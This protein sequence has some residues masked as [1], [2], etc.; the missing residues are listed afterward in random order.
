MKVTF[1]S[2]GEQLASS[3][4]R[5]TIPQQELL[6][7]G[8]EKGKDVLIYGKHFL[9]VEEVSVCNRLIFDVCDDHFN[10]PELGKYYRDHIAIADAVT[11]NSEVMQQRIKEVSGRN[12]IIVKEPYEHEEMCPNIGPSLFWYGHKSNLHTLAGLISELEYPV[13]VMSNHDDCIQWTPQAFEEEIK[14]PCIVIIPTGEKKAKSENRMVEAIRCGR[15]VC[16]EHLPSYKPFGEFFPLGDIP[17]HIERA[18]ANPQESIERIKEAQ[19]YIRERYSPRTIAGQ[20]MEVIN[21]TY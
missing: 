13:V 15:Y 16:A 10:H 18:L 7:M 9:S 6:K 3:R 4:L 12:A 21:G 19:A 14:K 8:I 5:A 2:F 11:C 17:E 20:W 1:A